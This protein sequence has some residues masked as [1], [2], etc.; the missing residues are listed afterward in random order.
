MNNY[1]LETFYNFPFSKL[2][3]SLG[4]DNFCLQVHGNDIFRQKIIFLY[5]FKVFKGP[6]DKFMPCLWVK[7]F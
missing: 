4:F 7:R 5:I 1:Y 6:L 3:I 2:A